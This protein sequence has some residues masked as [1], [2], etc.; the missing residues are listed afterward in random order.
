[1]LLLLLPAVLDSVRIA[2]ACCTCTAISYYNLARLLLR[3]A[4][5]YAALPVTASLVTAGWT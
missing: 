1:M 2:R 3:V 5:R 4:L